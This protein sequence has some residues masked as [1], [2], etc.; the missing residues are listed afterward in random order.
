[1]PTSPPHFQLDRPLQY[2][3]GLRLWVVLGADAAD[4]LLRHPA[5]C[6]CESSLLVSTLSSVPAAGGT[7]L[8]RGEPH[9]EVERV[10][11][12]LLDGVSQ[13]QVREAAR[14][15]GTS[16]A[17]T[18]LALG[19]ADGLHDHAR[20]LPGHAL[21]A[22]LGAS[23]DQL[24]ELAARAGRCGHAGE[25]EAPLGLA[26]AAARELLAV[27]QSIACRPGG[28]LRG[29]GVLSRLADLAARRPE[30]TLERAVLRLAQLFY[31]VHKAAAVLIR[32]TVRA[33]CAAPRVAELAG[34]EPA[35]LAS[36]VREMRRRAP[37]LRHAFRVCGRDLAVG[38]QTLRAGDA[39]VAV[40]A[41]EPAAFTQ[42][43]PPAFLPDRKSAKVFAFGAEPFASAGQLLAET[44]AVEAVAAWLRAGLA[45]DVGPSRETVRPAQGI[46][47]LGHF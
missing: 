28:P 25:P 46:A 12:A 45:F 30:V 38:K 37:P 44:L 47:T 29:T 21:G 13:H 33:L 3:P 27:M 41:P 10:V 22:L 42:A 14:R 2:D 8:P 35:L 5:C 9:R 6:L 15:A 31:L 11:A 18:G 39:L 24:A 26:P 34:R 1:M 32:N 20:L 7:C 23:D 36:F 16:L 40:W 17:A 19:R 43:I 4:D